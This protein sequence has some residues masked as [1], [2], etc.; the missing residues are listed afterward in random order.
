MEV[1]PVS[2]RHTTEEEVQPPVPDTEEQSEE[3]KPEVEPEAEQD[4][5][6]EEV[7]EEAANPNEGENEQEAEV[8]PTEKRPLTDSDSEVEVSVETFQT[9]PIEKSQEEEEED[10]DDYDPEIILKEDNNATDLVKKDHN[11]EEDEDSDYDPEGG[12]NPE[13]SGTEHKEETE[14]EST[15]LKGKTPPA[16]LPPKPPVVATVAASPT[17]DPLSTHDSQQ[18]LTDAYAAIMQSELVKNPSFVNLSQA[19]QMKLIVNEL[20]KKNIQLNDQD[21]VKKINYD[22]VYSYNK[23]FKNLKD[24]I[25]LIPLNEF[26]RRPNITA[27]MTP[28]E[29]KQYD[30]FIKTEAYYMELQNWDEFPDKSRL[31]IGN[32]PANTISKQ[33]LFRIFSQY[34]D[35]IQIAIK[36][37]YGFAQFRTA[38][39][40]YD[41]IRG[42]TDVPLH[43]KIMRL[44]ASKPQ[45]SRRPGRPDINNPNLAAAEGGR[46]DE[47]SRKK[48]KVLPD[49]QIYIT[50]K[51]SVFYIRKVK[52][53]FANSQITVDTEDVT[54][55]EI[56]EVISEA[57]YSGVLGACV[58]KELK[59]DVQTFESTPDGGIKF[60]EYADVDPDVAAEIL[61]KAKVKK[62]GT[63]MPVYYP[64]DTSHNDNSARSQPY[65]YQGQSQPRAPNPY[66]DVYSRKRPYSGGDS[67]GGHRGDYGSHRGGNSAGGYSRRG[68]RGGRGGRGGRDRGGRESRDHHSYE[69]QSWSNQGSQ[70]QY[71]QQQYGQQ[72]S[73][74]YDQ[75]SPYGQSSQTSQSDQ[76]YN[77][78]TPQNQYGQQQN[79]QYNQGSDQ[80]ALMQQLQ[81]MNPADLQQLV[82]NLQQQQPPPQQ[83]QQRQPPS[84]YQQ[85]QSQGY[86]PPP[87]SNNYGGYN[88]GGYQGAPPP[89]QQQSPN[90]Q[91][92]ALLSR[93]QSSSNSG[94][95]SSPPSQHQQQDQRNQ[96]QSPYSSQALLDTLA[97]LTKK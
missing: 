53:A 48:R 76:Y 64:Q 47:S 20:S 23:P 87:Q 26:C 57:A 21:N 28:E 16:G 10:D 29:E 78:Q 67:S 79:N 54:H 73:R 44:D 72:S 41:C 61:S 70:Q 30:D 85:Q 8:P 42:E 7:K 12:I 97:K 25:P 45:K 52:K 15:I 49:C 13:S 22:Q 95:Q 90:G 68:D 89:P 35:V 40:C 24:P 51:S 34:G 65:G 71:G 38:E 5:G 3:I 75:R 18:Q 39:A 63:N 81:G 56:N 82:A 94:Y 4:D 66:S 62:Y 37:G 6:K 46:S 84:H 1:T 50:G 74:G 86:G 36:A 43:N 31:F 17:L 32:L 19:E 27:P 59:V 14:V 83:Q 58:V 96:Q 92:E 33:D 91:V 77:Q 88:Q 2:V 69:N 93:I 9:K 80:N 60:D 55:R 11:E